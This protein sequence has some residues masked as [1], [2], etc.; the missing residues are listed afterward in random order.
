MALKVGNHSI[1][2]FSKLYLM[3]GVDFEEGGNLG[4]GIVCFFTE[5][6]RLSSGRWGSLGDGGRVLGWGVRFGFGLGI[7]VYEGV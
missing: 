7:G 4:D 2:S 6:E 1:A 3:W 5:V